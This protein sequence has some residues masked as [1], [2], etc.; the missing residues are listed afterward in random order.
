MSAVNKA[1]MLALSGGPRDEGALEAARTQCELVERR[2]PATTDAIAAVLGKSVAEVETIMH[3]PAYLDVL[4]RVQHQRE[5]STDALAG[6]SATVLRSMVLKIQDGLDRGEV[7]V[8]EIPAL[9]RPLVAILAEHNR[10]KAKAS[11]YDNLPVIHVHFDGG[12]DSNSHPQRAETL[13]VPMVEVV[14]AVSERS[15]DS[16]PEVLTQDTDEGIDIFAM[17]DFDAE[18]PRG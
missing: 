7:D 17:I 5:T 8:G 11:E 4:E 12:I 14:E 16:V 9:S 10:A 1:D 15:A 13:D 2:E 6:M 3:S 18:V